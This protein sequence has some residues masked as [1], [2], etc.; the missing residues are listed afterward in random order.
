[1]DRP[2]KPMTCPPGIVH[3]GFEAAV[4]SYEAAVRAA[5]DYWTG[6]VARGAPPRS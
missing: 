4:G 1:M 3:A 5:T 6:T 2:M